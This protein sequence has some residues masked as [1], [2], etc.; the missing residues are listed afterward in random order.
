MHLTQKTMVQSSSFSTKTNKKQPTKPTRQTEQVRPFA[1]FT[2]YCCVQWRKI[3]WHLC[4]QE[5][6]CCNIIYLTARAFALVDLPEFKEGNER[7]K[8][9]GH[10][11]EVL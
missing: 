7:E 2:I 8:T 3:Q 9:M 11:R 4:F 10:K 1:G 6:K 5:K